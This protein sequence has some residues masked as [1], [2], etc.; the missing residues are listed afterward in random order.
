MNVNNQQ[1][2]Y[3]QPGYEQPG[4]YGQHQQQFSHTTITVNAEPSQP[5]PQVRNHV[6]V[7]GLEP[8]VCGNPI[9]IL[10]SGTALVILILIVF[11]PGI[12]TMVVG[13]VGRHANPCALFCIGF[14]QIILIFCLIIQ[15]TW[16]LDVI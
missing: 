5:Q 16:I 9:P 13:C 4:V 11:F 3:K 8:N 2:F 15:Y 7:V 1:N 12:G 6:V 14:L 10:D